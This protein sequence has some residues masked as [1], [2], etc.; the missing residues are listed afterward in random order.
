MRCDRAHGLGRS[1][2]CIDPF[3]YR[4]SPVGL[5]L[6]FWSRTTI[7][8]DSSRGAGLDFANHLDYADTLE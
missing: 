4:H 5:S 8:M 2:Y 3:V 1:A 6:F 7:Y